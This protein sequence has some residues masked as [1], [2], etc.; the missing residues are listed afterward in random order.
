MARNE[1]V[2]VHADTLYNYNHCMVRVYC[3]SLG[4]DR[5][6]HPTVGSAS[7]LSPPFVQQVRHSEGTLG[8]WS[9]AQTNSFGEVLELFR[10][11]LGSI[12]AL[13]S[14]TVSGIPNPAKT[15]FGVDITAAVVVEDSLVSYR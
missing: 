7:L 5:K 15:N 14:I 1:H 8:C 4:K 13:H 9:D 3:G 2:H 12:V 6:G 11:I 10:V